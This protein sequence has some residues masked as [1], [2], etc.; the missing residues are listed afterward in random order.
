MGKIICPLC[1][2]YTSFN[3]ISISKGG[4]VIANDDGDEPSSHHQ[5][6]KA[7]TDDNGKNSNYGILKCLSC[8]NRFIVQ[9]VMNDWVAVYPL[10]HNKVSTH[11]PEPIKGEFEEAYLCFAAGAYKAAICMCQIAL[12]ATWQQQKVSD[13]K[14]LLDKGSISQRLF[15]QATQVRL[16]GNIVKH[17]LVS[18][19]A[20]KDEVEQLLSYLE[21]VL[22]SVYV[23]DKQLDD[24]S[25][26]LKQVRSKKDI[27]SK[28]KTPTQAINLEFMKNNWLQITNSFRGE[29]DQGNLDARLRHACEPVS[30]E[31]NILTL[32]FFHE[33]HL[34]Y[35]N[36]PKYQVILEKK[37]SDIMG[38]AIKIN[39]ILTPAQRPSI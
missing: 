13:L 23:E 25:R 6:V 3:P 7:Y 15:K 20:T 9:K 11:I 27:A 34:N 4:H 35:I 39:M 21:K 14:G 26:R 29:G 5:I 38:M 32:G 37:I 30:L 31:G 17:K 22:D 18:E 12:E 2:V 33:F 36:N 24:L 10:L 19:L 28:K 1:G 8:E 16:W